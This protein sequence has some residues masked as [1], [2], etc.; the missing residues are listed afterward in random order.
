MEGLIENFDKDI[1]ESQ[2]KLDELIRIQKKTKSEISNAKSEVKRKEKARDLYF[3]KVK[4]S[5]KKE[6]NQ[7][8]VQ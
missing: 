1:E 5:K 3:G 7:K 4:K 2:R 8:E 6:D